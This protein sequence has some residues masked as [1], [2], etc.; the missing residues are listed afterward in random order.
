MSPFADE[1]VK[2]A[3]SW[4]G[5]NKL[6]RLFK[7]KVLRLPGNSGYG[8][9]APW[10]G[11]AAGMHLGHTQKP[12]R[13]D[14][15]TYLRASQG[16]PPMTVP[17]RRALEGVVRGHELDELRTRP[18]AQGLSVR[19]AKR[20]RLFGAYQGHVSPE[21]ILKEHNK[22][23]T[24]PHGVRREVTEVMQR[25]RAGPN[26]EA[27]NLATLGLTYGE[28]SRLSRHAR[29]NIVKL[30]D[31]RLASKRQTQ[32]RARRQIHVDLPV[33]GEWSRK[34]RANIQKQPGAVSSPQLVR[35]IQ[36]GVADAA[37]RTNDRVRAAALRARGASLT[38]A[39]GVRGQW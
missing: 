27:D 29:K 28:G 6:T 37:A 39:L 36:L 38:H 15:W 23:V 21:V 8:A 20:R 12:P 18:W 7:A 34:V 3:I 11:R 16:G 33:L 1:M 26:K 32:R 24:L 4:E 35:E 10:R 25:L 2:L 14:A 19:G 30:F 13:G 9:S 5:L 17:G 22:L 31:A